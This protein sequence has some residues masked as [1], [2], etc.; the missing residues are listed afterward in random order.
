MGLNRLWRLRW[1][2]D[3]LAEVAVA[4]GMDVPFFLRGGG[5]LATGRGEKLEPILGPSLALVLVN[6]RF[7][8]ST[9]QAYGSVTPG[10]YTTGE[11]TR[12]VVE[13]LRSRR[14][15]PVAASLYNGLE[16]VVAHYDGYLGLGLTDAE[17]SDLV[18][19][20]KSL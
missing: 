12:A 2:L 6:P 16:A 4:L 20:L 14:S 10:M 3:R 19:Y 9:A 15:A 7:G 17:K 5:A 18:E 11:R 1:P 13:A 8:S